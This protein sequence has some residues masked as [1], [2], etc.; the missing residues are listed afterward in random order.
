MTSQEAKTLIE[1]D[2]EFV[3]LKRFDFSLSKVIERYP[4]GCPTRVIAQAL[5]MTEE[6]VESLYESIVAKLRFFMGAV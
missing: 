2:E 4:E 1:N 3:F 6:E 5:F